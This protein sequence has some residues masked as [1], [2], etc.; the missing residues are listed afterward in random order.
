MR[1]LVFEEFGEPA[2]VLKLIDVPV[3]EPKSGEVRVRMLAS[4]INPS[5]MMSIRGIY[6]KRPKLPATPGFEG[7]G[8]VEASGGGLL[9]K[10]LQG[11]RVAVLNRETGNWCDQTVLP[12]KQAIPLSSKLPLEQAAMFF[13]NP[14]TAYVMTR[15]VLAVPRGEWLLQTAAG[16]ALGQMVIRL[17]QH[18]GFKTLNVVRRS[19]QVQELKSLGA[20]AVLVFNPENQ[21]SEDFQNQVR[22]LTNGKGVHW[23]IDPVGGATGSAVVGCLGENARLLVYG[24]LDDQPLQFSPRQLMTVGSRVEGFWLSR[25]MNT[26]GLLAKLKLIRKIT[27]LMLSAI[28]VSEVSEIFPLEKFA[29]AVSLSEKP[30]R[31][32]KVLLKVADAK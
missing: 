19:E 27:Q 1:A 3:P 32:G 25:Y 4:P 9:G 18:F 30:G 13:V 6:G 31:G 5:D 28:L 14:A 24:T 7:V 2:E 29:E 20:D 10:F 21:S 11:K 15:E 12:A 8:I 17:G 16:S 26:L 23:A 22:N